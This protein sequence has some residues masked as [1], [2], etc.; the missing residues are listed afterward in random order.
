MF[1]KNYSLYLNGKFLLLLI[2]IYGFTISCG[3]KTAPHNMPEIKPKSTFSNLNVIQRG[4]RIRLSWEINENERVNTFLKFYEERFDNATESNDIFGSKNKHYQILK[5][6]LPKTS[7]D[8]LCKWYKDNY[9]NLL[10]RNH[11]LKKWFN[12]QFDNGIEKPDAFSK[13]NDNHFLQDYFEIKERL[14]PLNCEN[15]DAKWKTSLRLFFSSKSIIRE[16]NHFYYYLDIPKNNLFFREFKLIHFGPNGEIFSQGDTVKFNKSNSFPKIPVPSFKIIQI[17]D[18]EQTLQFAFGKVVIKKT[19]VLNDVSKI[20]QPN[21]NKKTSL[22]Q[23]GKLGQNQN[24]ATRSFI[25]RLTWPHISR[26]SLK[27]LHGKGDYFKEQKQFL[28]NLYRKRN[29]EV[30]SE[31]AINKKP[32]LSNYFLDKINLYF[33]L[34]N[35]K[36]AI[37]SQKIISSS[38]M[39]F[40]VDLLG[41]NSDTWMY[42]LRLIDSF[43]N[44][45]LASEKITVNLPKN[46][47]YGKSSIE[48]SDIPHSD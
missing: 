31:T 10:D 37:D 14:I 36:Q 44:E 43:G 39:A 38:Q 22:L 46:I 24:I 28:V 27:R 16:G 15:C 23:F 4:N 12:E 29:G 2:P 45:S 26:N 19:T 11:A 3:L 8:L 32:Q 42:K 34:D 33:Y 9:E 25:L 35:G 17:E 41:Q 6:R 5:Q 30:W 1:F 20:L 7:I 21:K 13:L 18:D 40:Y 48:K 47:I